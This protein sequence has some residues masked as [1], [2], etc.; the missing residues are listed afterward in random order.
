MQNLIIELSARDGYVPRTRENVAQSDVTLAIASDFLTAGERLTMRCATEHRK[1]IV[2]VPHNAGDDDFATKLAIFVRILNE[3]AQRKAG[4]GLILNG[5]GNGVYTL[6][7]HNQD[8]ADRFALRFLQEA[9]H[10]PDRRFTL[11]E[12]RSGGQTG[13]DIAIVKAALTLLIPARIHCARSKGGKFLIRA[14]DGRDYGLTE[15]EYRETMGL[16]GAG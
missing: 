13:Y 1:P 9:L 10:C 8:E 4:G 6:S 5:A 15:R 7:G 16:P 14:A 3:A 12:V 11:A 2:Q